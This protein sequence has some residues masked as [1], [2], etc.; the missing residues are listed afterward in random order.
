MSD[1]CAE[2]VFV[3][4]QFSIAEVLS[5]FGYVFFPSIKLDDSSDPVLF[6]HS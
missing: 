1:N 6:V 3:I 4:K 5:P 2:T